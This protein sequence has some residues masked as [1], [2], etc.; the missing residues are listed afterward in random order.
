MLQPEIHVAPPANDPGQTSAISA[1]ATRRSLPVEAD[2]S[3]LAQA[4][5]YLATHALPSQDDRKGRHQWLKGMYRVMAACGT[6]PAI[7]DEDMVHALAFHASCDPGQIRGSPYVRTLRETCE[8][9]LEGLRVFK[10]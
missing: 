1:V 9:A 6:P 8:S 5:V 2:I 3:M 10:R 4:K 7:T